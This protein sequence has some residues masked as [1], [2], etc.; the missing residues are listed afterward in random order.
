MIL[1]QK[2]IFALKAAFQKWKRKLFFVS[3]IKITI[4]HI[5]GRDKKNDLDVPSQTRFS[6]KI[7]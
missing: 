6:P 4:Y 2:K 3:S 7:T 5:L 1:M